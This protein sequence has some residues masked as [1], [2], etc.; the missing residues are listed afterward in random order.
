M[1]RIQIPATSANLGSGFDSLGIA[2][3]MYNQVWMEVSDETLITSKDDIKVPTDKSNLIYWSAEH[4]YKVCG[5]QFPGLTIIQENNIPMTRGLGSSSACIVAGLV[6]ANRFLGNPLTKKDLV[7]LASEI[8]GHPD[9][10]TPALMGGL[11]TSAIDGGKV[12]S[13]SVPVAE[14][15]RFGVFIPPFELSTE[16]ARGVLPETYTKEQAVFNLSRSSLMTSSLFSGSLEN[17]RVAVQDQLHQPYRKSLIKGY[18]TV[19][20]T[21]YELGSYG[22][23]ISGAGPTIIAI[24][25][26]KHTA[27]FENH[28]INSLEEKGCT[29][30]RFT[31][32]SADSEGAKI[33]L[34]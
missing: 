8:E 12:Y 3:T 10:T 25:D 4:L 28:A 26:D 9:N 30:W 19:F 16:Y 17:L 22:T 2:L 33:I 21:S 14:N 13:V 1:I 20:R 24:I 27:D 29:G 32:L 5:K 7:N 18:D 15:I 31:V 34:D 11:V 6:G 23:Y